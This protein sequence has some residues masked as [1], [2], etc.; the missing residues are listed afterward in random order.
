MKNT[1]T[2]RDAELTIADARRAGFPVE[3]DDCRQHGFTLYSIDLPRN[4]YSSAL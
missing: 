1:T 3:V 2:L 4:P